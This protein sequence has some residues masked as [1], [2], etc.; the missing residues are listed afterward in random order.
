M[1]PKYVNRA[2]ELLD[3]AIPEFHFEFPVYMSQFPLLNLVSARFNS[4]VT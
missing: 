1:E 2:I 3:L 4:S